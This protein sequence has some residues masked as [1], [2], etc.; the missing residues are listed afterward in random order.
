MTR[1]PPRFRKSKKVGADGSAST[2]D[3]DSNDSDAAFSAAFYA[4]FS[5][6]CA[7]I[8]VCAF[9]AVYAFCAVCVL[10]FYA[11]CASFFSAYAP[12]PAYNRGFLLRKKY[13]DKGQV[14][15]HCG[16][17]DAWLLA[18]FFLLKNGGDHLL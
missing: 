10:V 8:Y 1:P 2:D 16:H 4:A 5:A 6:A 17:R 11:V 3:D 14:I 9:C 13:M 7:V 18:I 15:A 12:H